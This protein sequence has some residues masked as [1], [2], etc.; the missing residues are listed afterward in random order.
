MGTNKPAGSS[1]IID[2]LLR[3]AAGGGLLTS[4]VFAPEIVKL[5][6]VPIQKYFDRLDKRS[7][8][9]ELKRLQYYMR[10]RGLISYTTDEYEHGITITKRGLKRLK[11][12]EFATLQIPRLATWDH[13][14]RLV[15]F[16]IPEHK[17]AGRTS[18]VYKLKQTGFIQLQRSVWCHPYPCR[19]EVELITNTYKIQKYV[20]YVE[21][22]GIDSE[23]F[24]ISRFSKILK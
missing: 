8:H 23:K 2:G 7:Q 3:V 24:L 5:L 10:Q 20:S 22:T 13:K 16:D 14:W 9:R 21:A 1:A 4:A 6:D 18:L 15:F 12:K 17:R 19:E 11:Q